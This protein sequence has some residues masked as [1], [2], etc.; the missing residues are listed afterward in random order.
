LLSATFT[1]G[2]ILTLLGR[3]KLYLRNAGVI[4]TLGRIDTIVLDKTGTIT[5]QLPG[6]IR[7]EGDALDAREK[8]LVY[9]LASQSSHPLSRQIAATLE[10][11]QTDRLAVEGY[12]EI[13]GKGLEALIRQDSIRL[14]SQSFVQEE[15]DGQ[16][17]VLPGVHL[18]LNNRV[19]GRFLV[20]HQYREGLAEM[21]GQLKEMGYALHVLS[22]D[23]DQD[24]RYLTEIFGQDVPLHFQQTPQG[25]LAYIKQLQ[26]EGRQVLMLGDGL[27]DAGALRQ[28]DAGIAVSDAGTQ[29]TPAS[30]GI[31][32]GRM[33]PKLHRLLGEARYSKSIITA[34]FVLSI[35]YNIVG[36]TYATQALL[37]PVVA[38]I[39]MPASSISIVLFVS[40]LARIRRH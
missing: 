30:D 40:V 9:A 6:R 24:R 11:E 25:K 33:V 37:S 2:N 16:M 31:L 17:P 22:G 15:E 18:R 36:L 26:Q 7:F 35:L 12:R 13:T 39:L 19:R 32:D 8:Q 20:R 21:V 38:A 23:N 4:E 5:E 28:A 29:F 10:A 1:Y 27:N 14:G 3:K 34:S